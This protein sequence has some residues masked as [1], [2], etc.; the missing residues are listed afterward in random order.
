MKGKKPTP[1][2]IRKIINQKDAAKLERIE[3]AVPK[4]R[5]AS[6][7][8]PPE[9]LDEKA[10]KYWHV[11]AS[12]LEQIN[13]L[14]TVDVNVVGRYCHVFARWI[15]AK[16]FLLEKGEKYPIYRIEKYREWDEKQEKHVEKTR[17]V[18]LRWMHY[19]EVASCDKYLSHMLK[20]ETELGMTP[21]SR[22]RIGLSVSR[23]GETPGTSAPVDPFTYN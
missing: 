22:T 10:L 1:I 13:L 11:V 2:E 21:S 18:L 4:A 16:E 6:S 20:M 23:G 15:E 17:N 9:W 3:Q 12:E 7:Q 8:I 5:A 19:P 14:T